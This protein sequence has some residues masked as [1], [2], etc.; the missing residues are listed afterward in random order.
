MWTLGNGQRAL[1]V[2]ND[3]YNNL[4]GAYP[5]CVPLMRRR[6]VPAS[7]LLV[8]TNEHDPVT[9][10]F[11]LPSVAKASLAGGNSDGLVTGATMSAVSLG[12]ARLFGH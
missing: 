1:I 12:L 4:P 3:D 5:L 7:D 6:G 2:S 11:V 8:A 9:G 10:A